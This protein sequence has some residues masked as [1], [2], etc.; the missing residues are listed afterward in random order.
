MKH[1]QDP[2]K[3]GR[4]SN[5]DLSFKVYY[6][7]Y[8]RFYARSVSAKKLTASLAYLKNWDRSKIVVRLGIPGKD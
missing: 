1:R 4:D 7:G 6:E 3:R 5:G 8:F 2:I